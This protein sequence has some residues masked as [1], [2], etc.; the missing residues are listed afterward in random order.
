MY[1]PGDAERMQDHDA[2]GAT[3]SYPDIHRPYNYY[4][5]LL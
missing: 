5:Y 3:Q 2:D 1:L 4:Y